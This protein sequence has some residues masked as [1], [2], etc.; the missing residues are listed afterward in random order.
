MIDALHGPALLAP[1]WEGW[2]RD[3]VARLRALGGQAPPGASALAGE[4]GSRRLYPVVDGAAIVAVA[5]LLVHKLG[6]VGCGWVTGYDGL[7][8]QLAQALADPEV[9]A[10][11]LDVDSGGGM[12]AGCFDLVDWIGQAKA[13]ADKPVAAILSETAY[14][15]AYAIASAADSIAVPRTGGVG[16]IGAVIMHVE[17]SRWLDREGVGVTL[18]AAGQHKV[19]GNPFQ[20]LPD[21]VRDHWQAQTE[22]ARR[23]F[24]AT[25]ARNRSAAGAKLTPD[26]ALATEA[27]CYHGP[28]GVAEAV[29]LGLADAILS[30]DDAFAAVITHLE[31][32]TR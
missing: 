30:P 8:A 3:A 2:A 15:A 16:S 17:L 9:R 28:E 13:A 7:R 24:A 20:V 18:I 23:L 21:A 11:V 29:R 4:T 5:G 14:S 19:D 12:V 22:A 1:G 31:T 32:T 27:R 25:V 26:Q 6:Y 10:V